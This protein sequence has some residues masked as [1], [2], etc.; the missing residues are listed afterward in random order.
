MLDAVMAAALEHVE[1]ADHIAVDVA[2]RMGERVAHT[3]LSAEM[4]DALELLALEQIAHAL[5]VREIPAHEAKAPMGMQALETSLLEGRIVVIV[6][7][8]ETDH[9]IAA[10]EQAQRGRRANKA[11]C[12]GHEDF[13]RAAIISTAGRVAT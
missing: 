13:H 7:I 12:A 8:V 9:L 10:L 5:P 2:V 6:E 3:G 11:G 4:H 1:R